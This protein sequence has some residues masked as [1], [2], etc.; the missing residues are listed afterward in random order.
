M[1]PTCPALTPAFSSFNTLEFRREYAYSQLIFIITPNLLLQPVSM[2]FLNALAMLNFCAVPL[3]LF[4]VIYVI[5][6]HTLIWITDLN[7]SYWTHF[8]P[9]CFQNYLIFFFTHKLRQIRASFDT[10]LLAWPIFIA[11]VIKFVGQAAQ[12]HSQFLSQ[13]YSLFPISPTRRKQSRE[14]IAA[15]PDVCK[16]NVRKRGF[17]LV[18]LYFFFS[19]LV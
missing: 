19:Y 11:L 16:R 13:F 14:N 10:V 6:F 3:H 18:L 4:F 7:H 1:P 9:L 5:S 8:S 12:F 17:Q 2:T 15:K